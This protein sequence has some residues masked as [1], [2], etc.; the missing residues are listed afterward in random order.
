MQE[1]KPRL[2]GIAQ[3]S[4]IREG[5]IEQIAC[6]NNICLNKRRRSIDR[7]IHVR[8]GG[9]VDNADRSMLGEQAI[10]QLAVEDVTLD[11]S[12]LVTI[13]SRDRIR[14]PGVSQKIQIDDALGSPSDKLSNETTADKTG[15]AGDQ[16][17]ICHRKKGARFSD[18]KRM[19]RESMGGTAKRIA[20]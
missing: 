8:F 13:R 3:P 18:G 10:D 5:G 2:V 12:V 19:Y 16:E 17:S 11:E 4:V 7:S 6:S 15:T 1:S 20:L 14:I 9:K